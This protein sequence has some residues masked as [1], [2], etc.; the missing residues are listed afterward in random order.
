MA[1]KQRTASSTRSS[2]S[3]RKN[4]AAIPEPFQVVTSVST[5]ADDTAKVEVPMLVLYGQWPKAVGFP[6]GAAVILSTDEHGQSALASP[7]ARVAA[8][9]LH[10]RDA[11]LTLFASP[12]CGRGR[13]AERGG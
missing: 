7:W 13:R 4:R 5:T 10:S 6:I 9:A 12:A 8:P 1:R 11:G 3:K 2:T